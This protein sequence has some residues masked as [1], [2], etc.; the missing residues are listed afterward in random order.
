MFYTFSNEHSVF[1]FGLVGI[2]DQKVFFL[3]QYLFRRG[4]KGGDR[5]SV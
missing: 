1:P 2:V 5:L 3:F 4:D